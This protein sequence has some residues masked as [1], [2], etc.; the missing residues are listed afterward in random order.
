[1]G[2]RVSKQAVDVIGQKDSDLRVATQAI[3]VLG[4][5][6]PNIEVYQVAVEYLRTLAVIHEVGATSTLTL[7]QAATS[8]V[9]SVSAE[10]TLGLSQDGDYVHIGIPATLVT[11][12]LG[13]SA[14]ATKVPVKEG[15]STLVVTQA[16]SYDRVRNRSAESEIEFLH[17]ATYVG[18]KWV[19]A[20][21]TI[22]FTQEA[23][24]AQ[25]HEVSA[26]STLV[27][28]GEALS[29]GTIRRDVES[30]IELSQI[31]DHQVK[32]RDVTSQII[33]TQA[34]SVEKVLTGHSQINLTQSAQVGTI[35]RGAESQL[36]LTQTAR[37]EPL[38]QFAESQIELNQSAWVNIRY[39]TAS[40]Q[41]D[42]VQAVDVQKPIRVSAENDLIEKDWL[43]D[44][45]AGEVTLQDIGLRQSAS[46]I[47]SGIQS[48]EHLLSFR[49][50][51][52][53]THV[54]ASGT[55][56][57]A[58][59]S[60]TLTQEARL[61]ETAFAGNIINLTQAAQGWAGRPCDSQ[62]ELTQEATVQ[63]GRAFSSTSTLELR[64][65][66]AYTLIIASSPCQYSPFIGEST[67]P[68]SPTP[69]SE[70][71]QGPMAGIQVPFQLVY[72]SVGVVTDSI[73]LKTPNLGNLDRLAFNRIQRETRGGTL[74]IYADPIWPKIETMVVSFSGLKRVEAQGL[75]TFMNDHLGQEVGLIDW[76]HRYWRGVI[77]S[78]DE[79]MVEDSFDSYTAGF[80][81][82]GELDPT[83]N[84]QVVPPSLRYSAIRSEQEGGYYVPNE[85]WMPEIPGGSYLTA[86]AAVAIK[87]GYP[88]YLTSS[89]LL[90]PAK[91]D[92]QATM[93]AIGVSI[94]DVQPAQICQYI[95]GGRVER[96][97]WTE[98]AGTALLTAGAMYYL[99]PT[100]AG[101]IT[102][103]APTTVGQY[104]VLLGRASS[105]TELNVEIAKPILL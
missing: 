32:I 41:L 18:P 39:L 50:T 105:P 27:L 8:S 15:T 58:S 90:N 80:E 83:W 74:I 51:V 30:I 87:V 78:P 70:T 67:D 25:I 102:T 11:L 22:S 16:A 49:E 43:W 31:A 9:T 46:V 12:S 63:A 68:N 82:Q 1:M 56:V 5:T 66:A 52:G 7:T 3:E 36:N 93:G 85:P 100:T 98:V 75:L 26:I 6:D 72:P 76:E 94:S 57:S 65:A 64:H 73:S 101:H 84:P 86:E 35:V 10:S 88:V 42:L 60:L 33:I 23:Y 92:A 71:L 38:P 54:K 17:T 4:T 61:S 44:D 97:D 79:P 34:A 62:L 69:P 55:S 45:D 2:L 53:L 40:S 37:F 91:A 104:V 14:V 29:G 103:V 20:D 21:S 95:T 77:V 99:S 19:E 28:S 13:Q 96:T 81:F 59:S 24:L 47:V 89:E 48:V